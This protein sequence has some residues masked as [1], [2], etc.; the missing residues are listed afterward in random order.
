VDRVARRQRAAIS[1]CRRSVG[2]AGIVC[3]TLLPGATSAQLLPT[4]DPSATIAD[5]AADEAVAI[6]PNV[7]T[8]PILRSV[9]ET[10]W[11]QSPTFKAK[12]S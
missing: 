8:T 9:L 5:D 11:H 2:L 1:I 10:M 3:L 6:P 12:W 7:V 4:V